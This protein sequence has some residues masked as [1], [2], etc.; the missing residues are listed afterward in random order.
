MLSAY[1]LL[2]TLH[3]VSVGLSITIFFIR[4]IGVVVLRHAW[5]MT[6]AWRRMSVAVDVVLLIA[7][8]LLWATMS[9]N[10]MREPWLGVKLLLLLVYIMLGSFALK[11][12]KTLAAK[13]RFMIAALLVVGLMIS[14]AITRQPLGPLTALFSW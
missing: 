6:G 9:H 10:P 4:G 14:I 3:L 13:R 12:A 1:P 5:P 11:R 7:G 2:L 8:A